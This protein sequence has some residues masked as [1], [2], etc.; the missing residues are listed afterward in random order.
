[1]QALDQQQMRN[2]LGLEGEA[3]ADSASDDLNMRQDSK[4]L[5]GRVVDL[6]LQLNETESLNKQLERRAKKAEEKYK[7]FKRT[8]KASIKAKVR[9]IVYIKKKHNVFTCIF[10][11]RTRSIRGC[12]K[13]LSEGSASSTTRCR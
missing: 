6:Q 5:A 1:M 7:D 4:A 3:S 2:D 13:I 12:L 10:G 11:N 9:L 8:A